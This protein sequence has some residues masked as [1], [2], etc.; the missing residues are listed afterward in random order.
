MKLPALGN[1]GS[2]HDGARSLQGLATEVGFGHG[3]LDGHRFALRMIA[4]DGKRR[5]C[6]DGDTNIRG[7]TGDIL[8]VLAL[9]CTQEWQQRE[10]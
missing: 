5:Q 6:P 8:D 3:G 10:P 4:A 9:T 7:R 2:K 1:E